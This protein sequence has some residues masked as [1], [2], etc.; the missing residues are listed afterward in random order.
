MVKRSLSSANLNSVGTKA[1]PRTPLADELREHLRGEI[2]QRLA[3]R[4]GANTDFGLYETT[5]LEVSNEVCQELIKK[6][7]KR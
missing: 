6:N 2:G 7:L 5:L 4:M 1:V 3:A